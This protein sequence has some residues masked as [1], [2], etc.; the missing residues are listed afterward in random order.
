MTNQPARSPRNVLG[1]PLQL[2]CSDPKTGFYRNGF[3]TTGAEDLG[4]HVVCAQVDEAFLAFTR[5]Q[6]NDL[7]TPVPAYQFPGLQAGDRWC[8]CASRWKEAHAA[9]FAPPIILE[10][11]HEKAL[12]IIPLDVLRQYAIQP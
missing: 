1:G 4:T 5:A 2:C 3:C 9:G 12:E 11:S 7:I 6:G 8:L 10:A